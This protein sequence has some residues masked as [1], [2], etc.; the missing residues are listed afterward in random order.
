VMVNSIVWLHAAC[1]SHGGVSIIDSL[2]YVLLHML[3][4]ICM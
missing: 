3:F 2:A 1:M 4:P